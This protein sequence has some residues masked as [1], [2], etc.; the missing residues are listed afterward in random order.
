MRILLLGIDTTVLDEGAKNVATNLASVLAE[1]D[2]VLTIHQRRIVFPRNLLRAARFAP[3]VILSVH[4]PG[5]RTIL[6]LFI[7][8]ILCGFSKTVT[9]GTQPHDSPVMLRLMR[10]IGPHL[11]FAQSK[12]WRE[13]FRQTGV[14]V[15]L[16]PNGVDL[17]KFVPYLDATGISKFREVLGIGEDQMVVLHIGPINDNRNYEL[18]ARLQRE[19][20]FQVIVIGSTSERCLPHLV[21]MLR[22]AGALVF[23]QYFPNI[24]QV[25]ALADIYL[26]PVMAASGSIEFPLTVLEALAC[27]RPVASTP[28]RGLPDFLPE[29]PALRYFRDYEELL[30]LIP[31]LIGQAGGRVAVQEF[32]WRAVTNQLRAHICSELGVG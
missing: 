31:E 6:L 30:R 23:M 11:V 5:P 24:S 2:E 27:D 19:T 8:R 7:L 22:S 10:W 26:F 9:I 16:L 4:G 25:Y 1:V 29:N 28:F 18:L 3:D 20:S 17:D 15:C 32:S 13:R 12:S 21:A 14:K